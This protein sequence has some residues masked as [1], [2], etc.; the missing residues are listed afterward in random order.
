MEKEIVMKKAVYGIAT[1]EAQAARIARALQAAGFPDG[2]ISVLFPDKTGSRD[3]AH[4]SHSKA[5]EGAT[6]GATTGG[7]IGGSL[8]WLVGIGSLAIPGVGPF[9][10]AGPI[11]ATMAGA[12]VGAA[13][14]GLTGALVGYGIPEYEAKLYD[15]KIRAGNILLSVHAEN[16]DEAK[17]AEEILK[18]EGAQD[19][20]RG[21][22]ASPEDAPKIRATGR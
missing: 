16:G 2:D 8:G 9:I 5:P 19:I 21:G 3:L 11:M 13:A 17:R 1:S 20:S 6:A 14:G 4:E 12:A 22:E 15:G 7:V 18:R 10:A